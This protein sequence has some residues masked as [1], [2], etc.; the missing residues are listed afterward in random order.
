MTAGLYILGFGGHARSVAD[1]A[2][3][4]GVKE[5]L[6][7][8]P[9]AR[10]GER[11]AGFAAATGLPEQPNA[12]WKAFAALGDNALR[13]RVYTE[14]T[15]PFLSLV[16]NTASVGK[17]AVIEDGVF[18]AEHAHVGPGAHIGKGAIVNTGA[19]VD[20]ETT[21]GDYSHVSINAS[22]A[23][24]CRIGA[25]TLIGAG[26]TVIDRISICDRAVVGAGAT[27]LSDLVEPG[28]YL[29]TPARLV[30]GS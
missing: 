25:E 2:L 16:A 12:G 30:R 19:I 10:V 15:I 23:G 21:I 4:I 9:N 13:R 3:S 27:V 1:V 7:I 29:G 22:I 5:L 24:R 8:D 20:H 28:V 11:F 6:F 18:I 14:T 17:E 26:A